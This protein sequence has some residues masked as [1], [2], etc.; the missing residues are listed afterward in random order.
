[1]TDNFIPFSGLT[2]LKTDAD[3]CLEANKG[4]LDDVIIIGFDTEGEF[5]FAGNTS[6]GGIIIWLLERA[7]KQLLEV[8][9]E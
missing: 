3:D 9:I 4:I 6:D 5:Y 2:K 7:K 1:M 8:E